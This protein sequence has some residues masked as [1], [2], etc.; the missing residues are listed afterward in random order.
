MTRVRA[1]SAFCEDIREEK[2]GQDT[3]I[4]ILPDNMV[5]PKFPAMVPKMAIYTRIQMD[6]NNPARP[7]SVTLKT[8]WNENQSVGSAD[9]KLIATAVAQAAANKLPIAGIVLKAVIS[10]WLL[11]SAGV[12]TVVIAS[13]DQEYVSATLNVLAEETLPPNADLPSA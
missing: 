3:I 11:Q 6:T 4:G 2:T 12:I 9:E 7:I 5:V 10:P 13:G 1:V 8:P